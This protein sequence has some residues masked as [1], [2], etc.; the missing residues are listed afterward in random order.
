MRKR[1]ILSL[2]FITL[3]FSSHS[4]ELWE[5]NANLSWDYLQKG[6]TP[7]VKYFLDKAYEN[8]LLATP[9]INSNNYFYLSYILRN[10]KNN[11]VIESEKDYL[12]LIGINL[13]FAHFLESNKNIYTNY[14]IETYSD[15]QSLY[16]DIKRNDSAFKYCLNG[17]NLLEIN[18]YDLETSGIICAFKTYIYATIIKWLANVYSKSWLHEVNKI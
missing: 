9:N 1:V 7:S 2:L 8:V 13:K 14:L 17:I 12:A 4:Q 10:I 3:F 15:L 6:D 5:I 18:N 16:S 11:N